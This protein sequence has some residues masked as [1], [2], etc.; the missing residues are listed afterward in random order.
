MRRYL[1]LQKKGFTFL[2]VLAT[3][4]IL[5]VALVPI[6]TWV[7]TVIQTKLKAERQTTAIFLCQGKVEELRTQIINNFNIDYTKGPTAFDSPYQDFYYN[8]TDDFN[9]QLKTVSVK[10]WHKENPQDE[11][12][13]YTQIAQR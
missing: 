2:E 13:F 9:P 1:K 11:T 6:M 5:S 8:I 3:L 7:P 4:I 10:V 12:I